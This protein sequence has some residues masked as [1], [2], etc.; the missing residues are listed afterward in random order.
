MLCYEEDTVEM[1]SKL[2]E[3]DRDNC[4]VGLCKE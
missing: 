1:E 4:L 2:T 3:L